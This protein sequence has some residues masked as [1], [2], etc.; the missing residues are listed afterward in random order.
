MIAGDVYFY[1]NLA[2]LA[3]T[4]KDKISFF[5]QNQKAFF[6]DPESDEWFNMMIEYAKSQNL[7]EEKIAELEEMKWTEMPDSLKLF[8]FDFCILNGLTY[9]E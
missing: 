6:L 2:E 5:D 1:K 9:E 3:Q 8:A 4:D 7:E